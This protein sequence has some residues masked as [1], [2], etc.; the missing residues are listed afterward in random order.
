MRRSRYAH[1]VSVA[2]HSYSPCLSITFL[3]LLFFVDDDVFFWI[4]PQSAYI[5][6]PFYFCSCYFFLFPLS[7]TCNVSSLHY[8]RRDWDFLSS[9]ETSIFLP[10]VARCTVP[11]PIHVVCCEK[12]LDYL[13]VLV[14]N[15][16]L[17]DGSQFLF[18][19]F[20]TSPP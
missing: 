1:C 19:P 4:P 11:P 2:P 3:F 18:S 5:L 12:P 17:K 9:V 13:F 16:S 6:H 14:L 10:Q 20:L 8:A 7:L 15:L